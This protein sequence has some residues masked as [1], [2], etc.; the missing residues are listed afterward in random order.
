VRPPNLR[1]YE[2]GDERLGEDRQLGHL[3]RW[4]GSCHQF[5]LRF[6][7]RSPRA[8]AKTAPDINTLC[9]CRWHVTATSATCAASAA[10]QTQQQRLLRPTS[11]PT[12]RR[13]ERPVPDQLPVVR[14]SRFFGAATAA[15][16]RLYASSVRPLNSRRDLALPARPTPRFAQQHQDERSV[17]RPPRL[18]S[19][20]CA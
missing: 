1:T 17:S 19:K 4:L 11:R 12:Y 2:A 16:G 13:A 9:E 14:G 6:A 18:A 15:D 3:H 7:A 8:L 10:W 5:L 20:K